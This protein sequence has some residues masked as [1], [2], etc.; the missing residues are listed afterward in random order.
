MAPNHRLLRER[1]RL[2]RK[3]VR[4]E[5]G[6]AAG[7]PPPCCGRGGP[8]TRHARR[9]PSP[10]IVTAYAEV[11]VHVLPDL[12]WDAEDRAQRAH[13]LPAV[14]EAYADENLRQL[15]LLA[16]HADDRPPDRLTPDTLRL[17][18]RLHVAW[19]QDRLAQVGVR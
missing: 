12:A 17:R 3:L 1:E 15:R 16:A 14:H 8:W 2:L 10:Q 4:L 18:L 7:A 6:R 9:R 11:L 13:M 19:L 5:T